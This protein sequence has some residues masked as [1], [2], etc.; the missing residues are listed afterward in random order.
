[1]AGSAKREQQMRHFRRFSAMKGSDHNLF[2]GL[3]LKMVLTRRSR[4]AGTRFCDV[5]DPTWCDVQDPT[6]SQ[7]AQ[8]LSAETGGILSV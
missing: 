3:C 4:Q 2:L 6:W 1:M 8:L 5:Q 7:R